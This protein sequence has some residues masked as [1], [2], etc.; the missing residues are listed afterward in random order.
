VQFFEAHD[1]HFYT[2]LC[3]CKIK[4]I[5]KIKLFVQLNFWILLSLWSADAWFSAQKNGALRVRR[6]AGCVY[7]F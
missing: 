1:V 3:C 2:D 7:T 4:I 6:S 5:C